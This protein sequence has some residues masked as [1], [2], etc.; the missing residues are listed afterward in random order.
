[1]NEHA[2]EANELLTAMGGQ[3]KRRRVHCMRSQSDDDIRKVW[4][5][6]YYYKDGFAPG[7]KVANMRNVEQVLAEIMEKFEDIW[8]G[9]VGHIKLP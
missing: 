7:G 9:K 4:L 1:M 6:R 8:T 2:E 3:L 5:N